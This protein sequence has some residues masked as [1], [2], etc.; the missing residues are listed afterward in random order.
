MFLLDVCP[1]SLGVETQGGIMSILITR[2]TQVPAVVKEIFT[3]AYDNQVSVDV[4]IYQ[5]ER[6]K[7][8]DNLCLGEFKLDGIEKSPRGL[9]KIEVTFEIDANGILSVMAQDIDTGVKKDIDI[10]IFIMI[11]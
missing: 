4:K 7:T 3:T 5:G 1:L 11:H 9:P 8:V 2:N 10:K 6:P